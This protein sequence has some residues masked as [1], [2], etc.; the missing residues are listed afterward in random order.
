MPEPSGP[1]GG[2]VGELGEQLVEGLHRRASLG[3]RRPGAGARAVSG[4]RRSATAASAGLAALVLAASPGSPARSSACSSSSQVSSAEADGHAG[5]ER[6]PGQPVGGR[7]ADVLEV[8]RAAADHDAER[9]DR[10]VARRASACADHGQLEGAGHADDGRVGD[11]RRRAARA[12]RRRAGRPSPWSCQLAADDADPQVA[13]AAGPTVE[14]AGAPVRR[15]RPVPAR[16]HRSAGRSWPIRS[17]LV[18]QVAPVVR[19]R[20]RPAAATRSTIVEAVA[21]E[22]RPACPGCWSAAA[23]SGRRGRRGSARRCRSRGRRRAGRAR[24]WRRRCRGPPSC[25]W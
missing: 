24:G 16:S 25:S 12:A 23:S 20:R 14:R 8:R 9:D 17:R 19:G 22:A 13:G 15:S 11:A 6:D 7:R 2:L 1:V 21:L 10:V 4:D 5:V 18:S 3:L